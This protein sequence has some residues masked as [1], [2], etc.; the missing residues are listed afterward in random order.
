M[1]QLKPVCV[2]F[3][4]PAVFSSVACI[5]FLKCSSE[6]VV[7]GTK[8]QKGSEHWRQVGQQLEFLNSGWE[9]QRA[10]GEQMW[11]FVCQLN[12]INGEI[13][14]WYITPFCTWHHRTQIKEGIVFCSHIF[15]VTACSTLLYIQNLCGREHVRTVLLTRCRTTKRGNHSAQWKE[16]K[17]QKS[18]LS[19]G[20]NSRH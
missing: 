13:E 9:I 11:D 12:T 2:C 6:P 18:P 5:L 17:L 15:L 20:V 4:S 14:L 1:K 7:C 16:N 19:L 8:G 10:H 3:I